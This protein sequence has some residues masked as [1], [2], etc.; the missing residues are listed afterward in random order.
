MT[1]QHLTGIMIFNQEVMVISCACY[2]SCWK[3][4]GLKILDPQNW[5]LDLDIVYLYMYTLDLID[6]SSPASRNIHR[7]YSFIK[8]NKGD[9]SSCLSGTQPSGKLFSVEPFSRGWSMAQ[10]P[11]AGQRFILLMIWWI[12]TSN[13]SL[14]DECFPPF[15][16]KGTF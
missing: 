9:Q 13:Y 12:L 16:W 2:F 7:W 6:Q 11:M 4:W 8:H 3:I 1:N 14:W 5:W 15:F 10:V